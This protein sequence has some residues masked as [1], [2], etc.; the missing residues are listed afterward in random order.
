M[1]TLSHSHTNGM[2][3][4][5]FGF[6]QTVAAERPAQESNGG[7]RATVAAITQDAVPILKDFLSETQ[8][9]VRRIQT[10]ERNAT[11]IGVGG[12]VVG[13]G[14]GAGVGA[15][16]GSGNRIVTTVGAGAGAFGLGL[17]AFFLARRIMMPPLPGAEVAKAI[18]SAA[19]KVV[20]DALDA[21]EKQINGGV[22]P[23][24]GWGYAYTS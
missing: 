5:M 9:G 14:L 21:T 3:T 23:S 12:G 7:T 11:L 10:A 6:G 8:R 16:A 1:L 20:P 22:Q 19:G 24:S 2:S 15:W 4:A 17:L 18:A 13:V